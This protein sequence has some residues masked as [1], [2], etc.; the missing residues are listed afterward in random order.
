MAF[1][2]PFSV[3]TPGVSTITAAEVNAAGA[4]I[5]QA[6]DGTAAGSYTIS[7]DLVISGSDVVLDG[8][9]LTGTANVELAARSV[10]R[11]MPYTPS[12]VV[13][14]GVAD[15]HHTF[16]GIFTNDVLGGDLVI[17]VRAPHGATVTLVEVYIEGASAHAG[18]PA[19]MPTIS[20]YSMSSS[21]AGTNIGT[22]TDASAS[23]AA[24]QDPH[25]ISL[26]VSHLVNR[27]TGRLAVVLDAE[28]GANA[29]VGATY[30]GT[31]VTYNISGYDED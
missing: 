7:N 12:P 27:T 2:N 16:V 4:A 19:N 15:W 1:T 3:K 13:V 26:V 10:A 21:G 23:V 29:L 25:T 9:R 18:L 6:I 8:L 31:R 17:P 28:S 5:S 24:Y 14:G 11:W 22:G 30:I 20:L